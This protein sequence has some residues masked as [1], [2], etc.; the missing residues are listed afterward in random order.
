MRRNRRNIRPGHQEITPNQK[1]KCWGK[2]I[3]E[4]GRVGQGKRVHVAAKFPWCRNTFPFHVPMNNIYII[5]ECSLLLRENVFG[6]PPTMKPRRLNYIPEAGK[7][8]CLYRT[9]A[10][11][12]GKVCSCFPSLRGEKKIIRNKFCCIKT[13]EDYSLRLKCSLPQKQNISKV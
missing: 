10:G 11:E 2:M 1:R 13:I 5:S 9:R 6:M 8:K 4:P 3:R 7:W 12:A